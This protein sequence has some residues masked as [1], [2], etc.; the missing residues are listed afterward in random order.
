M[1]VLV[2]ITIL[3]SCGLSI[4]AKILPQSS[5][6]SPSSQPDPLPD[7]I[8]N[9]A[10]DPVAS[11]EK[12][13]HTPTRTLGDR[14]PDKP[15][16]V[17]AY[18]IPVDTLGFTA[19]GAIYLGQRNTLASLDFLGED[20]LLF[21]F[22]VPG[23]IRRE[24]GH[25][26][27]EDERQIRAL[28]V[29]IKTGQAEAEALWTVHDRGRYLWMLKDGHFVLRDR[30]ILQ[31]GDSSLVLKPLFQFPGPVD[32][33]EMDPQQLYIVTNSREPANA[34]PKPGQVDS[35]STAQATMEADAQNAAASPHPRTP[36]DPNAS[37][38]PDPK[39]STPPDTV[40]R[41]LE[42]STGKVM[43]VSRVRSTVHLP[44]NSEGYLERL[45]GNGQ[46]W[47]LNLNLFTGGSR[48]L[49]RVESSC[50]PDLDFISQN[51]FLIKSCAAKGE[52]RMI[53]FSTD[54]NRLWE[55]DATTSAIWPITVMGPD[56]SRLARETLQVSH[57][58]NAFNPLDSD[59][60][61]GQLV[62]IINTAD[63]SVALE[64]A[65]NPPL[66]TGGNVAISPTGNRAAILTDGAIQVFDL[67]PPAAPPP[68]PSASAAH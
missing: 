55:D 64:S 37:T 17:P 6:L 22:R 48:V 11:R 23:L 50:A 67:P 30:D 32:W 52:P 5:Q 53:A 54:G 3:I 46:T 8:P 20:H 66:D 47:L 2:C 56:G 60:I 31:Q 58:V 18:K 4:P 12:A 42:R 25:K 65:A 49:G 15:T 57:A 38:S 61:K 21:T 62:R 7:I 39:S 33:L 51:E 44:I 59:D 1:A 9:I 10:P 13:K 24:D 45:R 36:P 68:S 63:G 35:P 29:N 43:L 40:V 16:L 28:V 27:G 19:P 14:L 41:I 34:E 26:P